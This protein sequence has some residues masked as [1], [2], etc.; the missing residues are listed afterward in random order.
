MVEPLDSTIILVFVLA[1]V[2]NAEIA[3]KFNM[4]KFCL[5]QLYNFDKLPL[6]LNIFVLHDSRFQ[7]SH[8]LQSTWEMKIG[9]GSINHNQS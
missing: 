9:T 1:F 7:D 4:K 8:L 2:S 6:S 5:D 3:Y